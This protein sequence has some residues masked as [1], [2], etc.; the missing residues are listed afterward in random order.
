M[1]SEVSRVSR[2][3]SHTGDIS[4]INQVSISCLQVII[5]NLSS[6]Q[7]MEWPIARAINGDEKVG[8]ENGEVF[9]LITNDEVEPILLELK[10]V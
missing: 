10:I 2:L 5:T 3:F 4:I 1:C 7:M 9:L 6:L 8:D